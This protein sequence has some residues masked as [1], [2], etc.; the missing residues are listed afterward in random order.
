MNESQLLSAT[1]PPSGGGGRPP[2]Q[3]FF[4]AAQH[5][6]GQPTS[7]SDGAAY[8]QQQYQQAQHQN[9]I[10]D[11]EPQPRAAAHQTRNPLHQPGGYQQQPSFFGGGTPGGSQPF[12]SPYNRSTV[13]YTPPVP[14]F[15]VADS[16]EQ[17]QSRMAAVRDGGIGVTS[18]A[19]GGAGMSGGGYFGTHTPPAHDTSRG[20]LAAHLRRSGAY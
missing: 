8:Q 12:A 2:Q 4:N 15:D 14:Q 6:F 1:S 20:A 10:H 16:P 3:A 18:P 13:P 17:Y 7:N 9:S 19:S 11:F 5:Q